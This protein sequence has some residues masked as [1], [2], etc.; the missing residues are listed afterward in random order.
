MYQNP[1]YSP[2]MPGPPPRMPGQPAPP[3][4]DPKQ[5]A[6]DM[7]SAPATALMVLAGLTIAM[8]CVAIPFNV[9]L[10]VSG[11]AQELGRGGIDPV[12]KIVVR[13]L[14]ELLLLPFSIFTFWGA[15]QMKNLRRYDAARIAAFVAAVPCIGPCCPIG[16]PFGI[17][18]VTVLGKPEIR[19]AFES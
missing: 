3:V 2:R 13:T 1:Y 16:I 12:F 8:I 5:Q 7:V 4:V 17:W 6:L 10:L 9:F 11:V 19:S 15:V 14:W 18:A